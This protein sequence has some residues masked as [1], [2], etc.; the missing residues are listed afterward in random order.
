[1]TTLTKSQKK[2]F[3]KIVKIDGED[4]IFDVTIR[5]DDSCGNGHNTFSV[6][7]SLYRGLVRSDRLLE[8]CG[9]IHED[10]KI[11]FPEFKN[12][13]KW[14]LM[15]TDE[16]LHYIANTMYHASDKDYNG[17]SKGEVQHIKNGKSGLYVWELKT[18]NGEHSIKGESFVESNKEPESLIEGTRYYPLTRIGEGKKSDLKAARS[19][20]V[21]PDATLEQLSDKDLLLS[22]LA[23][24]LANFKND[25]EALG[26]TY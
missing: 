7:G 5:H 3:T 10:I 9:C 6:T 12:I 1:M 23:E 21:W 24:L 18:L 8:S 11:H 15:S 13:L 14:H 26:F 19:C 2:T 22:R 16:P 4:C 25:V 17:L 20:A